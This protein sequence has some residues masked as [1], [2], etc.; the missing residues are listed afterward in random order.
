MAARIGVVGADPHQ[1]VDAA[2]GLQIAVGVLA[3]DQQGRRL[4]PGL[5]ARMMI[6]QL[7]LIPW[8][9]PQRR[10]SGSSRGSSTRWSPTPQAIGAVN[11]VVRTDDG[12]LVGFNSDA[13]G[14][15][16][17][18]E[19]AMGRALAGRRRRGRGCRRGRARGRLRVPGRGRA[20]GDDRQPVGRGRA[21]ELAT[22][23]RASAAR[24]RGPRRRRSSQRRSRRP[25]SRSTRRP[26][27]WSI[28]G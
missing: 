5:L 19:L 23:L 27:G 24:P 1:A 4:D 22:R 26:S 6:D 12:R 18:V 21:G 9:S 7:D 20:A 10:T 2:F 15:R 16:A 3:F 8:R 17:G 28:R 25:T 11:N 14:F 13:P